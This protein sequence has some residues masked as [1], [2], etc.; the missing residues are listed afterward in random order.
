[1]RTN[2]K[3]DLRAP[4]MNRRYAALIHARL[5]SGPRRGNHD[6]SNSA[7]PCHQNPSQIPAAAESTVRVVLLHTRPDEVNISHRKPWEEP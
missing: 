2:S 6:A 3:R 5:R 1:M 7:H 4:P